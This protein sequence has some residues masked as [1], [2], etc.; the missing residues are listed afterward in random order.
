MNAI[1]SNNGLENKKQRS[2]FGY[3]LDTCKEVLA[4]IN[5]VKETIL[6]EARNTFEAPE[7]LLRLAL[8]EAEALA[9]QTRYPQLVFADLA[10]ENIQRTA[11]WSERQNLLD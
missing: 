7:Q 1:Q 10:E 11:A 4:Q 3:A 6:T 8:S 9:F 5:N 2:P